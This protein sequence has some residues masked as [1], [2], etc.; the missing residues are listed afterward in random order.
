[1]EKRMY[2]L[3]IKGGRVIDP[4]QRIDGVMDMAVGG[5]KIAAIES[6]IF[7]W[8]IA[9]VIDATGRI[10]TPPAAV[11]AHQRTDSAVAF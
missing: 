10:V 4:S 5:A 2:D 9:R 7:P 11:R 8:G 6:N 3:L 1:V